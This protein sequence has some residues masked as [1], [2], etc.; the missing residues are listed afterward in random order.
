MIFALLSRPAVKWVLAGLAATI[1]IAGLF[2]WLNARE[3]ADDSANRAAGAQAEQGRAAEAAIAQTRKANDAENTI[4]SDATARA[5][6]CRL[7]SRTPENCDR[8]HVLP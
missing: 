6:D 4:R 8:G 7:Y 2:L 1:L 5:N 3:E